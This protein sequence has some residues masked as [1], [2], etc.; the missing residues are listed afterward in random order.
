LHKRTEL[1]QALDKELCLSKILNRRDYYGKKESEK[2][3]VL[4]LL[5]GYTQGDRMKNQGVSSRCF[6]FKKLFEN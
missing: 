5:L 2:E 3:K 1:A 4:F 6:I